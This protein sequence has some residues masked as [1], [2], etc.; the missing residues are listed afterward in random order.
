[1]TYS[2]F[3]WPLDEKRFLYLVWHFQIFVFSNL[4]PGVNVTNTSCFF[5]IL[6]WC[7]AIPLTAN[8]SWLL[9]SQGGH[10][11]LFSIKSNSFMPSLS[12][13]LFLKEPLYIR[14]VNQLFKELKWA[15]LTNDQQETP[16]TSVS[17]QKHILPTNAAEDQTHTWTEL[18]QYGKTCLRT[19]WFS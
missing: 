10:L 6:Q 11:C 9:S 19:M 3:K 17:I 12:S 4:S 7:D 15:D 1:M 13:S 2:S 8:A 5:S 16:W 14:C 18:K